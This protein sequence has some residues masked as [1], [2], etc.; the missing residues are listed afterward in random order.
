[1]GKRVKPWGIMR[2]SPRPFDG[3]C[4]H[5]GRMAESLAQPA[6]AR[7]RD[8]RQCP[9]L[10]RS[11]LRALPGRDPMT[12]RGPCDGDRERADTVAYRARRSRRWRHSRCD[13][14]RRNADDRS[15]GTRLQPAP[16]G[17]PGVAGHAFKMGSCGPTNES[18]STYMTGE[19]FAVLRIIPS[20]GGPVAPTSR[21]P[22][23]LLLREASRSR[24][25]TARPEAFHA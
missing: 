22:V 8:D 24:L 3:L 13:A 25:K 21:L 1:M 18:F 10:V 12:R 9:G 2:T 15:H 7:R 20:S 23:G 19:L 6:C 4:L 5:R 11:A 17:A 16:P 14:R